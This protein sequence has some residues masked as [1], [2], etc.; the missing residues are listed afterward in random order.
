[1]I[2]SKKPFTNQA[3]KKKGKETVLANVLSKQTQKLSKNKIPHLKD[4]CLSYR[5]W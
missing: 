1:M 4:T 2:L 3:V 5:I